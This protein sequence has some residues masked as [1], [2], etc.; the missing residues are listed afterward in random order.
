MKVKKKHRIYKTKAAK[1]NRLLTTLIL[2]TSFSALTIFGYFKFYPSNTEP[3]IDVSVV[4]ATGSNT[5]ITPFGNSLNTNSNYE[6]NLLLRPSQVDNNAVNVE[7]NF[8]NLTVTGVQIQGANIKSFGTCDINNETILFTSNKV[9]FAAGSKTA[10]TNGQVIAKVTIRTPAVGGSAN[11]SIGSKFTYANNSRTDNQQILDNINYQIVV[12]ATCGNSVV[13]SGEECDRG[14]NNGTLCIPGYGSSCVHCSTS[15]RNTIVN[16]N[17]RCGDGIVNGPEVCD[18]NNTSN[19]DSCSSDCRNSCT[20]PQIWNGTNCVLPSG[21][22]CYKCSANLTDGNNCESINVQNGVCPTGYTANSN[23]AE[24]YGLRLYEN[25]PFQCP[26]PGDS[27]RCYKCTDALNDGNSCAFAGTFTAIP[28]P[29]Q[30]GSI[31]CPEGTSYNPDNCA[32]ANT[33][34]R[35]FTGPQD[36]ICGNAV[37]EGTEQCDDGNTISGDVC[38][39]TCRFSIQNS[40]QQV[41]CGSLDTNYDNKISLVDFV[42]FLQSFNKICVDNISTESICGAKDRNADSRISMVDF[43]AFVKKFNRLTCE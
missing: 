1:L 16:S 6:L 9:C 13:D 23:C 14:N 32:L 34:G 8:N 20:P 40:D 26:G 39:S 22:T 18:D 29:G 5:V 11:I 36:T 12:A 24:G 41:Y 3:I 37:V 17:L 27:N 42:S 7:L 21:L 31:I 33:G 43:A 25:G 10:F 15:C 19:N 30:G 38:N 2:L 35:C 4:A 28:I